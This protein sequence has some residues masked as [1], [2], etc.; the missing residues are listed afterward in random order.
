MTSQLAFMTMNSINH[1]THAWG[2]WREE[3]QWWLLR[4]KAFAETYKCKEAL[5]ENPKSLLPITE[6]REGSESEIETSRG[7]ATLFTTYS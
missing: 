7:T 4:F 6:D 1:V 2:W 3:G 5:M